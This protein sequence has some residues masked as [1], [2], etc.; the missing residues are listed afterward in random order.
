MTEA[1]T[2]RVNGETIDLGTYEPFHRQRLDTTFAAM[3]RLGARRVVELGGHPWAMTAKMAA[4]S[5]FEVLATVS[6][7][8]LL[9]W[10]D[11]IP[12]RRSEYVLESGDGEATR[13]SNYSVNIERTLFD[14]EE[15]PDTVL[16]CEIVEHLVRAPHVLFLN[17][18]RWLPVGGKLLATTPNG[19]Q[20]ANPLRR[21]TTTAA[22]RSH[23]YERHHC[24]LTLDQLVDLIELS[25]F[26]VLEAEY[27]NVYP[28]SGPSALYGLLGK[29]P[30]PYFHAKFRRTLAVSAE[31]VADVTTLPALP[32]AYSPSGRW[33]HIAHEPTPAPKAT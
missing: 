12:V 5:D 17:A 22:Y 29:L 20:F 26:R 30:H 33:E 1:K 31:K 11:E 13:F 24:L 4:D 2:I 27:W 19:A 3:R 28:R 25:G 23:V 14:L 10:P 21:K 6:A 15:K 9:Y 18:N 32:R 16:A 7:E 8:E